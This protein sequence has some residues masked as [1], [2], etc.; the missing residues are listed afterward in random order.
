MSVLV[1]RSSKNK[2][3]WERRCLAWRCDTQQHVIRSKLLPIHSSHFWS[4]VSIRYVTK[5]SSV[6]FPLHSR[7]RTYKWYLCLFPA[8]RRRNLSDAGNNFNYECSVLC[9]YKRETNVCGNFNVFGRQ[10]RN[11]SKNHIVLMQVF[12]TIYLLYIHTKLLMV[13]EFSVCSHSKHT[14]VQLFNKSQFFN[15][16]LYNT[17]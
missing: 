5:L 6:Q 4:F 14:F 12:K 11:M 13:T 17:F 7:Q 15:Q 2:N 1:F 3:Y 16:M 8:T 9:L 10:A